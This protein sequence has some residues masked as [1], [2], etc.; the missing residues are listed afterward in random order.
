MTIG[1]PVVNANENHSQQ[2]P[3]KRIFKLSK[4]VLSRNPH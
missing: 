1:A 2:V 4:R 3:H